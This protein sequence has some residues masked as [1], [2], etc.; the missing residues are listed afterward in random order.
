MVAPTAS[1]LMLP[2]SSR[3][4]LVQVSTSTKEWESIDLRMS[5]TA[6]APS[7]TPTARAVNLV[8]N[9][10]SACHVILSPHTDLLLKRT[11]PM[12]QVTMVSMPLK[13]VSVPK[14]V[15]VPAKVVSAL[16]LPKEPNCGE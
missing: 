4:T 3:T 16:C 14:L 1:D 9:A 10:L 8:R 11:H 12:D 13:L 5:T 6:Q 2:A 15:L 7:S